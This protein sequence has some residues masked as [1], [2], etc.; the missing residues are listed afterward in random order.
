MHFNLIPYKNYPNRRET[1]RLKFLQKDPFR[2]SNSSLDQ[3]EVFA[4]VFDECFCRYISKKFLNMVLSHLFLNGFCYFQAGI[5][6]R[7]VFSIDAFLFQHSGAVAT[8]ESC[9]DNQRFFKSFLLEKLG[10]DLH[11]GL[12]VF[13]SHYLKILALHRSHFPLRKK[14][15]VNFY[16]G[17]EHL[18][19][20]LS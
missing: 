8:F 4:A 14:N 3:L 1:F 11:P 20:D 15:G 10:Y 12:V 6:S 16:W 19:F 9:H 7:F 17:C 18:V 13:K 2:L 5:G